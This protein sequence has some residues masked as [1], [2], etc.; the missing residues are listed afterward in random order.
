MDLENIV[1]R[2]VAIQEGRDPPPDLNDDGDPPSDPLKDINDNDKTPDIE[3]QPLMTQ[4]STPDLF[5]LEPVCETVTNSL[6]RTPS[7]ELTDP[8][9]PFF[10]ICNFIAIDVELPEDMSGEKT[11]DWLEPIQVTRPIT[12]TVSVSED[13]ALPEQIEKPP[14]IVIL[15][16]DEKVT[17]SAAEEPK[18]FEEKKQKYGRDARKLYETYQEEWDRLERL[19]HKRLGSRR[20]SVLADDTHTPGSSRGSSPVRATTPVKKSARSPRSSVSPARST[21]SPARSTATSKQSTA[22]SSPARTPTGPSPSPTPRPRQP[23]LATAARVAMLAA[24]FNKGEDSKAKVSAG[25]ARGAVQA[26]KEALERR[27]SHTPAVSPL[28]PKKRFL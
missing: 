15:H 2:A 16:D 1:E 17:T 28:P 24:R 23:S 4:V 20:K 10:D 27:A 25:P 26:A 9:P 14:P 21:T 3:A 18:K 19:G 6:D 13:I 11:V 12:E 5:I 22:K 7:L 8:E